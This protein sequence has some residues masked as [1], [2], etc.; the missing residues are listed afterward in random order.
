MEKTNVTASNFLM[1]IEDIIADLEALE[2]QDK[3][4]FGEVDISTGSQIKTGSQT[5]QHSF[6]PS[7]VVDTQTTISFESL[8]KTYF[9]ASEQELS[10]IYKKEKAEEQTITNVLHDQAFSSVQSY[11]GL[12]AWYTT[13]KDTLFSL[14]QQVSFLKTNFVDTLRS[15]KL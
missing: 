12:T 7:Q 1:S 11:I 14:K 9:D 15:I 2:K 6:S 13:V 4:G 8:A 10:S 3:S 5:Q